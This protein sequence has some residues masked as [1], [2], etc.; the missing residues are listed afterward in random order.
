MKRTL[1][2]FLVVLAIRAQAQIA[3]DSMWAA[4]AGE[5]IKQDAV[6]HWTRT[7]FSNN[8]VWDGTTISLEYPRNAFAQVQLLIRNGATTADTL[9]V[10]CDSLYKAAGT[11][12]AYTIKNTPGAVD[13]FNYIGRKIEF[14]LQHYMSIKDNLTGQNDRTRSTYITFSGALPQ[15]N[16]DYNGFLPEILVPFEAPAGLK[17]NGQGG[18]PFR[19]GANKVQGVWVKIAI[20]KAAV[21]GNYVGN[22]KVTR[23]ASIIATIPVALRVRNIVL[24]DSMRLRNSFIASDEAFYRHFG[25]VTRNA[26][27]WAMAKKYYLFMRRWGANYNMNADTTEFVANLQTVYNGTLFTSG[28]GYEG[29]G[30][31]IAPNMYQIGHW[32]QPNFFPRGNPHDGTKAWYRIAGGNIHAT[33]ERGTWATSQ[34]YAVNDVVYDDDYPYLYYCVEAHTS[35]SSNEP[36]ESG[37]G[38]TAWRKYWGLLYDAYGARDHSSFTYSPDTAKHGNNWRRAANFWVTK[39]AA[40]APGTWIMKYGPEE[41]NYEGALNDTSAFS[42]VRRTARWLDTNPVNVL[43]F[44]M[45]TGFA[46]SMYRANQHVD[47]LFNHFG[48]ASTEESSVDS[49]NAWIARGRK[50]GLYGGTRPLSGTELIDFPGTDMRVKAWVMKKY[51][52]SQYSYWYTSNYMQS[53]AINPWLQDR[54][55]YSPTAAQAGTWSSITTYA[56]DQYV[57]Y[58]AKYFK[59]KSAVPAG[60]LPTNTTYWAEAFPTIKYGDGTLVYQLQDARFP[61]DSR[62][63]A[64]PA[65]GIRLANWLE[66]QQDYGVMWL[67]DSLGVSYADIMNQVVPAALSQVGSYQN[68]RPPWDPDDKVKSKKFIAAMKTLYDRIEPYFSTPPP[69]TPGPVPVRVLRGHRND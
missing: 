36:Q 15:P 30:A 60:T 31:G 19:I 9:N 62:G 23:G 55:Q 68:P 59:A 58:N 35:G 42:N 56:K 5:R 8:P 18:A 11:S 33:V 34:S 46:S 21:A 26:A 22:L 54:N 53:F 57:M 39:F 10:T 2:L 47:I 48:N 61:T 66:G 40:I 50:I 41:P 64:G 16:S 63:V 69:P 24:S 29:P 6:N 25:T 27:F 20:P 3:E 45:A 4:P 17:A 1:F 51:G 28:N 67:A 52:I 65:A 43:D 12:A 7:D 14:Y 37:S 49:L 38:S 13:P 44:R 32:D